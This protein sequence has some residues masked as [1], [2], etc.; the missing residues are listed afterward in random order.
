MAVDGHF[1]FI[2]TLPPHSLS[3]SPSSFTTTLALHKSSLTS[4]PRTCCRASPSTPYYPL[5]ML[6]TRLTM[7][8][9]PLPP[10]YTPHPRCFVIFHP[11]PGFLEDDARQ[12]FLVPSIRQ[13]HRFNTCFNIM[14]LVCHPLRTPASALLTAI[15]RWFSHLIISSYYHPHHNDAFIFI[16]LRLSFLLLA[17]SSYLPGHPASGL[18]ACGS[19]RVPAVVKPL[20]C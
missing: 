19:A 6:Q 8:W 2:D 7:Y 1:F 13:L 17:I 10:P 9:F 3:P 4:S 20:D 5:T 11:G 18:L 12:V 14:T 16:F 15:S